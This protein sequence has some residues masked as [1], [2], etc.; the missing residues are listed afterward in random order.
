MSKSHRREVAKKLQEQISAATDPM[1]IAELS[2]QL[3]KFLPRPKQ[4][5]R[6]SQK[7]ETTS[8]SKKGR[9]L[10]EKYTGSVYEQTSDGDLVCWH[11]VFEIEKRQRMGFLKNRAER[12][13]FKAEVLASLT[14]EERAAY[15]AFER[16]GVA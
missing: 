14:V 11:L 9:S 13:A 2:N 12:T 10:R 4:V 7:P 8:P 15:E 6:R 5:K 3:S 16:E 1:V